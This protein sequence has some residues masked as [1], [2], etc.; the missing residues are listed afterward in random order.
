MNEGSDNF[1][2]Q[3]GNSDFFSY[4]EGQTEIMFLILGIEPIEI[5][6]RRPIF[7]NE[8]TKGKTVAPAGSKIG[9]IHIWIAGCSFLAPDEERFFA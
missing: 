9:H 5:K 1:D 3:S 6:L 4:V 7:M 8:S 2:Q